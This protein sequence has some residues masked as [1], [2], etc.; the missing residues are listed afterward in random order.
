MKTLISSVRPI[1][2]Y[3]FVVGQIALAAAWAAGLPKAEPAFAALSAFT[4]MIVKDYFDA[5]KQEKRE[6]DSSVSPA[7]SQPL[8]MK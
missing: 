7:P 4:M 3:T 1:V 6:Q 8:G 5:R 2:T